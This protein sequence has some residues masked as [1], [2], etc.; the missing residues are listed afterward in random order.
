MLFTANSG[1]PPLGKWTPIYFNLAICNLS[2]SWYFFIMLKKYQFYNKS[3]LAQCKCKGRLVFP[4]WLAERTV[5]V[6]VHIISVFW[7]TNSLL[8]HEKVYWVNLFVR[9]NPYT[10]CVNPRMNTYFIINNCFCLTC[11]LL[12]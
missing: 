11:N 3:Q 9:R 10:T 8:T 7:A 5:L 6:N 2:S 1:N 4:S 12:R